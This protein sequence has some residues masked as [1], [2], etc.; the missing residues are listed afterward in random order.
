L[1][2]GSEHAAAVIGLKVF[3]VGWSICAFWLWPLFVDGRLA[4]QSKAYS[5]APAA[6]AASNQAMLVAT[7]GTLL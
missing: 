5:S 2:R 3:G 1:G 7:G 6:V 4:V